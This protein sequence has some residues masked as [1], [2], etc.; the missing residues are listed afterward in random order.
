MKLL[1]LYSYTNDPINVRLTKG[2]QIE[3]DEAQAAYLLADAPGCFEVVTAETK[4]AKPVANK[5]VQSAPAD[6]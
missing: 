4:Q 2:E 5:M 6:K 3:V 1:V